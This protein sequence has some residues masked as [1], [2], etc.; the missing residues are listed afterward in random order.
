MG[1]IK[2]D[3]VEDWELCEVWVGIEGIKIVEA[4]LADNKDGLDIVDNDVPRLGLAKLERYGELEPE[5]EKSKYWLIVPSGMYTVP[6][7]LCESAWGL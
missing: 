1:G 2:I 6:C 5:E 3:P 4:W 7:E